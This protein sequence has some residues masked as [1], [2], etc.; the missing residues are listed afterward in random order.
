MPKIHWRR[1]LLG[2]LLAG[3]IVNFSEFIVSGIL[4]RDDWEQAMLALNR[5]LLS[6]MREIVALQI[7][8]LLTGLS[9][10][11]LYAHLID[12]YGSGWSTAC[13][14]GFAVWVVGYFS[15]TMTGAAMDILPLKLAVDTT[16]A[17]LIEIIGAS[18]AGAALYR[19]RK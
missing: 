13:I 15:G 4:L 18:I 10:V 17:G 6:S 9:T 8:G 16:L 12:R 1:V 7:W 2:G 3:L 19:P 14:A 5:P 11:A